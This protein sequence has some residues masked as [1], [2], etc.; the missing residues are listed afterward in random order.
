MKNLISRYL[1]KIQTIIKQDGLLTAGKS[2]FKMISILFYFP[3]SADLLFVSSGAIGD[4]WRY[5]VKNVA[6]ELSLHGISSSIVVQENF[7]LSQFSDKFKIY[8]FHRTGNNSQIEKFIKKLKKKNREIIFE[9]DDLLFDP[10]YVLNQDF[11]ENANPR[12]KK[13]YEKGV[14]VEIVNDEYVKVCTT[15][16]DFLAAKL[17]EHGKEV[18]VVPNKLSKKDLEI[19]EKIVANKASKVQKKCSAPHAQCSMVKIG[20]FSGAHS[21]NKDFATVTDVLMQ[22]LEKH[23][24]VELF[25]VGP[26]DIESRLNRFA[27]RVKQFPYAQREK[28]FENVASVDINI[29][30]L[31]IGNSFCEAKSELKYFEA[32]IVEVPTVAA[33]TDPFV[34]AVKDGVDGYVAKGTAQ[35][36]QKLEKLITDEELR[37]TMG[38]SAREKAL[39]QYTTINAKNEEYYNYLK[40]KIN[41]L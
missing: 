32:G 8:I 4:S 9:T 17:R 19:A 41:C 26:L 15:T 25:L 12:A 6:E 18:F 3:P 13:F 22:I 1:G 21:H 14:G 40:S 36:T 11:Y 35:W 30:P 28:H 34:R 10:K 7:W 38:K 37:K 20:Y 23:E 5:R 39:A 27:D 33:A 2:I 24:N 29:A 31:E 16:T